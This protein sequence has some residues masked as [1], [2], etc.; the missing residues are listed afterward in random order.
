M[1]YLRQYQLAPQGRN[2]T[3][4]TELDQQI[5]L[6]RPV[7]RH[8]ST[9]EKIQIISKSAKTVYKNSA[10]LDIPKSDC[11]TRTVASEKLM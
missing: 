8:E 10:A 11:E 4:A 6:R 2:L 1:Q 7:E 3:C 9:L 5:S